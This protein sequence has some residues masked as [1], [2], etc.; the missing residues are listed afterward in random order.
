MLCNIHV[1]LPEL[2]KMGKELEP[3]TAGNL[4]YPIIMLHYVMLCYVMFVTC[5]AAAWAG[6]SAA[7]LCKQCCHAAQFVLLVCHISLP[8]LHCCFLVGCWI[9]AV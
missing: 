8:R 3:R 6:T 2:A 5:A 1:L 4:L 9:K 7:Q